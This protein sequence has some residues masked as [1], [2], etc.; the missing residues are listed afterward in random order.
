MQALEVNDVLYRRQILKAVALSNRGAAL[1]ES[2]RYPEAA[3][4]LV[5][6]VD[7]YH[8]GYEL[9]EVDFKAAIRYPDS[10]KQQKKSSP[11]DDRRSQRRI[12]SKQNKTVVLMKD[13]TM[14]PRPSPSPSS[15]CSTSSSCDNSI[16]TTSA[17]YSTPVRLDLEP[18]MLCSTYGADWTGVPAMVRLAIVYNFALAR[19]HYIMQAASLS[20]CGEEE[21][22]S[23]VERKLRTTLKLYNWVLHLE[24]DM[25]EQRSEEGVDDSF[26]SLGTLPCLGLIQN[27][28]SIY[29]ALNRPRKAESMFQHLLSSLVLLR[30]QGE[31]GDVD[32]SQL[33]GFI[34]IT[35]HLI[36]QG[37]TV[38]RAA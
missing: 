10:V 24:Q 14:E 23:T 20:Q 27:C 3:S 19:H 29:Q 30:D 13:V 32:V 16:Y 22:P 36:L 1:I 17:L 9:P 33:D 7:Q 35:S 15:C 38:A 25:E 21:E 37:P 28:A 8:R 26:P 2:G 6:A 5:K 18:D 4:L 11:H 31:L 34:S 12:S